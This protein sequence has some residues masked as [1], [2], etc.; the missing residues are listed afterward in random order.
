MLS[1]K[2]PTDPRDDPVFRANMAAAIRQYGRNG[3]QVLKAGQRFCGGCR[4]ILPPAVL[5]QVRREPVFCDCGRLVVSENDPLRPML[6][7]A[8]S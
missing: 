6:T 5:Q 4:H 3:L 1:I 2:I 8:F 7:T